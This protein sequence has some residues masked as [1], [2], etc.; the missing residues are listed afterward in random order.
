MGIEDQRVRTRA[1]WALVVIYLGE[2]GRGCNDPGTGVVVGLFSPEV[3]V[4]FNNDLLGINNV[5]RQ[6]KKK[7]TIVELI[8]TRE[9]AFMEFCHCAKHFPSIISFNPCSRPLRG[10][11][12][13]S[14]C[15]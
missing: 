14:F 6:C 1:N 11:I 13:T 4:I 3:F 2:G 5:C 15:S 12:F 9:L 8:V 10:G 7:I